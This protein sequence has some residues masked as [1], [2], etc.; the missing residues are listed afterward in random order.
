MQR[1][2]FALSAAALALGACVP[3]VVRLPHT[4]G[5]T[6]SRGLVLL[7]R[8][9]GNVFSR[10]M[11]ALGQ[12]VAAAGFDAEVRNHAAWQSIGTRL[13][14]EHR[15]GRLPRPFAI[16][17][18]SLGADDALLLAGMLG[19]AGIATDMVITFDPTW[20]DDVPRGPRRVINF[21]QL[22]DVWGDPLRP[23]PGFD[24][25]LTNINVTDGER[26]DHFN[27]HRDPALHARAVEFL[28]SLSAAP[29]AARRA[30][31]R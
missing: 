17:G 24:G 26:I 13:I 4:D 14:A 8:G 30:P 7:L 1:R 6:P 11:D 22:Q 9:I 29:Q 3:R 12:R 25:E 2:A 18:H 16:I 23:G 31:L 19:E 5:D 15:A 27:I 20:V 28:N 10:G 21:Y